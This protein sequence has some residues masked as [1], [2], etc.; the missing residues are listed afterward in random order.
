MQFNFKKT[1][2]LGLLMCVC[3]INL[4]NAQYSEETTLEARKETRHAFNA[5]P[6][7]VAFGIVSANYEYLLKPNHGIMVRFD[8]EGIPKTYS[9]ANID[10]NGKAV[11]LN[12][13]YHITAGMKGWFAGAYGRYRWYNGEGKIDNTNFDFELPD[14]TFGLNAGKRWVWECG[15]TATA[16]FGY[17]VSWKD[18]NVHN[19]TPQVEAA[20]DVFEE[21]YDFINPF[22]G[23][24]SIGY[25]F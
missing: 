22:M 24:L 15:L 25:T 3:A 18:R 13:R 4:L 10:A 20:I 9:D 6:F 19:S 17:G 7:G 1:L 12:Y 14:F 11:V 16:A 8:Y 2:L 23:E 5:C 21:K